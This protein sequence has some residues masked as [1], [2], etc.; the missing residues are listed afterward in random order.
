MLT[1]LQ[2]TTSSWQLI[3][4]NLSISQDSDSNA[5]KQSEVSVD[6]FNH[7]DN[8]N[9]SQDEDESEDEDTIDKEMENCV[10]RILD[11]KRSMDG[12]KRR[13]SVSC[14]VFTS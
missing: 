9:C 1:H 5:N 10:L 11:S 4:S 14:K 13:P 2:I 7:S 6:E 8:S 3:I 12:P